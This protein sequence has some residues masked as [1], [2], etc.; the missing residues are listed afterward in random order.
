MT[1]QT[2]RLTIP[3]AAEMMKTTSL[4]VMMHIKRGLIVGEEIDGSSR[5]FLIQFMQDY[6]GVWRLEGM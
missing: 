3:V 1:E 2:E 6:Q 4:N 5:I